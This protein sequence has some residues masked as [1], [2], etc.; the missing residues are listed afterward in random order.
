MLWI[1]LLLLM[2][3]G[4]DDPAA[5]KPK[6][7]GVPG[8]DGVPS[9]IPEGVPQPG[10]DGSPSGTP[11][12]EQQPG[13]DGE[14][15]PG[16]QAASAAEPT[17]GPRVAPDAKELPAELICQGDRG[18]WGCFR[19]IEG[20]TFTMGAQA[21]DPKA[22][23]YDPDA[24][25][26]EAPP[27]QV[28]V[29][30]FWIQA[31]ETTVGEYA[32]CIQAGW[33]KAEDALDGDAL[34]QDRVNARRGQSIAGVTWSGAD[35]FCGWLGGRL[36]TEAE[37]A[38]AARGA[39]GRRFPW[40]DALRC[41]A[42]PVDPRAQD[43]AVTE[44]V[45]A[46]CGPL[47]PPI[48]DVIGLE[49]YG[50]FMEDVGELIP[51]EELLALCE[52]HKDAQPKVLAEAMTQRMAKTRAEAANKKAGDVTCESSGPT[53]SGE[54]K[55]GTP[56][57]VFGMAGS[58][59][60]WTRDGYAPYSAEAAKDPVGHPEATEKAQRSG[61]W[62]SGEL[63]AWRAAVRGSMPADAKLPDV[64]FRCVWTGDRRDE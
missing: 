52:T 31:Y 57:G 46:V 12:T 19:K 23:G 47:I 11:Q 14:A 50:G 9:D 62:M 41:P 40:G 8:P 27:H 64:G 53:P 1:Q 36:P 35:H 28:T 7:T 17:Q 42:A 18:S 34:T 20:A 61:S 55:D 48:S 2:A 15:L 49:A 44:K 37:W 51:P 38:L 21:A 33:C 56:D 60:E 13:P 32:Q 29:S 25:P 3:C 22:P 30:P 43:P 4:G 26:E 45:N 6:K 63:S 39:E 16:H 59:W 5:T 10:P 58:L 54:A 24:R